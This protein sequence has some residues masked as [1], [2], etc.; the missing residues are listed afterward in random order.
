MKIK[1]YLQIAQ[2]RIFKHIYNIDYYLFL[3]GLDIIEI[4]ENGNKIVL[5]GSSVN[6][7]CKINTSYES[8]TGVRWYDNSFTA[9]MPYDTYRVIDNE[10]VLLT[11]PNVPR[12]K[13]VRQYH[14]GFDKTDFTTI[15]L[16]VG[17]K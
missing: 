14:C 7:T 3:I 8:T 17:S 1:V 10:T 15:R 9:E 4:D 12:D 13:C 6:L 16:Y 11:L 5:A 2:S